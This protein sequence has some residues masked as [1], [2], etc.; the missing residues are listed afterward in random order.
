MLVNPVCPM[1][2]WEVE[3]MAD[4]NIAMCRKCREWVEAVEESSLMESDDQ[5]ILEAM[6]DSTAEAMFES[7]NDWEEMD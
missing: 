6:N 2:G 5:M 7:D 4:D 3:P 1:C